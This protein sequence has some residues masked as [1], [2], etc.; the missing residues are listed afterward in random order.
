MTPS[1]RFWSIAFLVFLVLANSVLAAPPLDCEA[2]AKHPGIEPDG[3]AQACLEA[4]PLPATPTAPAGDTM[5][6]AFAHE[7]RNTR[8][9]YFHAH[10]DLSDNSLIGL[11]TSI[12]FGY[13]YSPD[14][15]TL[16][17]INWGTNQLGTSDGVTFTPIGTATRPKGHT[18]SGL[19]IDPISGEAYLSST[20]SEES[21]LQS[22]DLAT[23]ESTPIANMGDL[24][25]VIEI[26]INCDG[27][28]YAHDIGNDAI[29]TI[30][31]SDGTPTLVG[32]HGLKTNFAQ[33][34]DFNNQTGE[35]YIYA[36][37]GGGS[38]TYGR[39]NLADGSITPLNVD[40]P[41]GEWE[42]A[43]RTTCPGMG[44]AR[45]SVE[46]DF[47]D[48][49][50]E[51][52][53]VSIS[54]NTGLPLFQQAM[55][56]EQDGVT[57]VVNHFEDGELACEVSENVPA[58]YQAAYESEAG[59]GESGCRYTGVEA[60]SFQACT[61]ANTLQSVEVAVTKVWIDE[62][63]GLEP[64]NFAQAEWTCSNVAGPCAQANAGGCDSGQ[65]SFAG[66]TATDTFAVYPN[67][68]GGTRCSVS[69]I[70]VP[71][72]NIEVDDSQ[73]SELILF[74]GT[75]GACAIFNT[76]LYAGIP[77]VNLAG[78]LALALLLLA[79]G[80]SAIRR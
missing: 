17:G 30:N 7:L 41:A 51:E 70:A 38:I 46:K 77:A 40:N 58:G 66:S 4:V 45:F 79:G 57:F 56:S 1:A 22:V 3:Y 35:L 62:L 6:Q 24:E 11:S 52:V 28:M 27:T 36:Y 75:G 23:G 26:A 74:P 60:G 63:P 65:L 13:D 21:L 50:P 73:C 10:E 15:E 37:I 80:L 49:N 16:Y 2:L 18:W 12:I 39:V 14:L 78:I 19:A 64:L 59:R 55:I 9:T 72:G 33:G 8:N 43:S 53:V 34:M 29:Y 48:D 61:I 25:L 54:C 42:G 67:W 20:N 69:E 44:P 68:N 31:R 71:D 76:R 47:D 5:E 32:A